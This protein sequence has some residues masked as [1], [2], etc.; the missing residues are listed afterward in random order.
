MIHWKV[1]GEVVHASERVY[2][3]VK[4]LEDRIHQLEEGRMQTYYQ[5][6]LDESQAALDLLIE[7]SQSADAE[8]F[9]C[10]VEEVTAAQTEVS[11]WKAALS[12]VS[13]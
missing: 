13:S 12:G 8:E 9:E 4:E 11:N 3:Y 2:D 10:L 1:K 5:K 6:M 7:R